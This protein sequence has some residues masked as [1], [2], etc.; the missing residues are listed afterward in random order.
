M[1]RSTVGV[2]NNEDALEIEKRVQGINS[3]EKGLDSA[4]DVSHDQDTVFRLDLEKTFWNRTRVCAGNDKE[5]VLSGK[6]KSHGLE[7]RADGLRF[8]LGRCI[9]LVA[10]E[11]LLNGWLLCHV[12]GFGTLKVEN[13]SKRI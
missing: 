9:F 2:V 6:W 4:A 12:G 10:L 1:S 3:R 5:T 8:V 7:V 11:E 13:L